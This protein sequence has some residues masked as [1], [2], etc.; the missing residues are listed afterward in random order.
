MGNV[1]SHLKHA[2][3]Y[4]YIYMYVCGPQLIY[5]E[6]MVN[7]FVLMNILVTKI[8]KNII[9]FYKVLSLFFQHNKYFKCKGKKKGLMLVFSVK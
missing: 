6:L 9:E 1:T 5:L 2:S 8:F 4:I 7:H 3:I